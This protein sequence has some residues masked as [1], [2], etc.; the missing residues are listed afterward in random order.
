MCLP[1]SIPRC[2][3]MSSVIVGAVFVFVLCA[4]TQFAFLPMALCATVDRQSHDQASNLHSVDNSPRLV[5]HHP[6]SD[7]GGL[8][9]PTP[10]RSRLRRRVNRRA[11][12]HHRSPRRRTIAKQQARNLNS[13]AHV[14]RAARFQALP[15]QQVVSVKRDDFVV[16]PSALD[17]SAASGT[18]HSDLRTPWGWP[19]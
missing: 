1:A 17:A 3:L 11:R 15:R 19:T 18:A 8:R 13:S 2:T 14:Y 6:L 9:K 10:Q 5:V 4:F 12:F 7:R 16:H